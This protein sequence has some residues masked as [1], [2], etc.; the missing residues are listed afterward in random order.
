MPETR[1]LANRA[2]AAALEGRLAE[3]ARL[4]R[5][6]LTTHPEDAAALAALGL[7]EARQNKPRGA[8]PLL[9]GAIK[10]GIAEPQ[11]IR[12]Y[13]Q[14]YARMNGLD[15][16]FEH[17]G[18]MLAAQPGNGGL[19]LV[20]AEASFEHDDV[21][22]SIA[23]CEGGMAR[24]DE[25]P[26]LHL[27]YGTALRAC[28]RLDDAIAAL[29]R[30]VERAPRDP[31]GH[32]MRGISLLA[33]GRVPEAREAFQNAMSAQPF[34]PWSFYSYMR[35]GRVTEGEPLL[36]KFDQLD[37]LLR[38]ADDQAASFYHYGMG[39]AFEDLG[40]FDQAWATYVK[41]GAKQA[42]AERYRRIETEQKFTRLKALFSN[43][44]LA[45]LSGLG[46]PDA[47]PIF[48][49]GMPRS[50]STLTEQVLAGHPQVTALGEL[51]DLAKLCDPWI[52]RGVEIGDI[53]WQEMRR[54]YVHQTSTRTNGTPTRIVD[55]GLH[56]FMHIGFIHVLFPNATILHTVRDPLD[57]CV[58]CLSLRFAGGHAWANRTRDTAHYYRQYRELMTHWDE[59]L[60]DRVIEA[61]YEDL[62]H[63]FEPQARRL[64]DACGLPWDPACLAFQNRDR[65]VRTA[66]AAQVRKG[67]GTSSIGRWKKFEAHLGD[68]K[69]SLADYL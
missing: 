11:I 65:A 3:A 38:N 30:Y 54:R 16:M 37:V 19:R 50:G 7:V 9:A 51:L 43:D 15:R 14:I 53:P 49:V 25:T 40:R 44:N 61:R 5:E 64:I 12:A 18:E 47:R 41:G 26:A 63:D 6:A 1:N 57:T 24:G 31:D 32:Y 2:L 46:D 27:I 67:I 13:G 59:V 55:K 58:S 62:A 28:D 48:I 45:K 42:K 23:L 68:L 33:A 60:P 35:S 21:E 8:I 10:G 4:A 34:H 17:L 69:E 66:S 52:E 22:H 39:K 20:L 36:A 29:D 56:N